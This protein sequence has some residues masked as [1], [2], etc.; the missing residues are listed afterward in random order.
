MNAKYFRNK[1]WETLKGNWGIAIG[2]YL[3]YMLIVGVC[4]AIPGVGSAAILIIG[5]PIALG[6]CV[7]FVKLIRG[8]RPD[9]SDLFCGFEKCFL[10]SFLLYLLNGV[11]VALWSLLFVIPGIVKTYSY[12]MST[13]ILAD[14]PEMKQSD[15]RKASMA[16]MEGNKWRLFCL[17]FSFIGW[18]ILGAL[19]CGILYIWIMPYMQAANA[20]FY[21]DLKSRN[22]VTAEAEYTSEPEVVDPEIH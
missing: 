21:E 17:H 6:L 3:L 13:Y 1:A 19:T 7:A 18:H 5:G 10:E 16:M 2:L 22:A 9:V 12:A 8:T 20:A 15:A 14:N 4:S 11:F